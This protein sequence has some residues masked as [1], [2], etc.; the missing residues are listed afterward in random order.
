MGSSDPETRMRQL[1]QL[2]AAYD[3]SCSRL[4]DDV[5]SAARH[6]KAL[7][8]RNLVMPGGVQDGKGARTGGP[9]SEGL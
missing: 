9:S 6:S 2:R 4:P 7:L 5:G 3:A 1:A 8:R